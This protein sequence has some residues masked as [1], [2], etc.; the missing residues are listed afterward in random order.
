VQTKLSSIVKPGAT[1][2]MAEEDPNGKFYATGGGLVDTAS[3]T[4]SQSETG[5][6]YAWPRHMSNKLAEFAMCDG[7]A[8]SARTN[9]WWRNQKVADNGFG[10]A[11]AGSIAEEWDSTFKGSNPTATMYWYPSPLTPN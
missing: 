11:G 9:E 7:S 8:R 10:W 5:G 3:I 4:A 2:E 1:V 6:Y